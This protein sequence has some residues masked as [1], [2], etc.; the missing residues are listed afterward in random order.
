MRQVG[1]HQGQGSHRSEQQH[2]KFEIFGREAP[3]GAI[4][5]NAFA[6]VKRAGRGPAARTAGPARHREA[7]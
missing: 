4:E 6:P 1:P 3:H 2:A 7:A 5:R